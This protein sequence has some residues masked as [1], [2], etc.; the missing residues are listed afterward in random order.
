M[1]H[2]SFIGAGVTAFMC[3]TTGAAEKLKA[4]LCAIS[5]IRVA[6]EFDPSAPLRRAGADGHSDQEKVVA[7][8]Q[9]VTRIARE[10]CNTSNLLV[11]TALQRQVPLH[12]VRIE[13]EVKR[14]S[15]SRPRVGAGVP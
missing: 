5:A 12:A 13:A 10:I 9:F 4:G 1:L 7:V 8:N 6:E 2:I 3:S 15:G 14:M 11:A